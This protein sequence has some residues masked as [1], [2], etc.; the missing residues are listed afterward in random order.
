VV[1]VVGASAVFAV[2]RG[3]VAETLSI[4]AWA[5]A[6]FATLYFAPAAAPL[7]GNSM[8]PVAGLVVAYIAVFLVVLIPLSFISARFAANVQ[9]SSVGPL[10]RSLGAVFGIVR[11]LILISLAYILFT[12]IVPVKKQPAWVAQAWTLPLVQDTGDVLLSLV[13]DRHGHPVTADEPLFVSHPH[14]AR[15]AHTDFPRPHAKPRTK[16]AAKSHNR[17]AKKSYGASERQGLDRLIQSTS[18]GGKKP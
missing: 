11:G 10:D 4:F 5:A 17:P 13:P 8:S 1:A 3:F 14:K 7:L 16:E 12:L 2:Y 15:A 9:Q 18:G 6:A